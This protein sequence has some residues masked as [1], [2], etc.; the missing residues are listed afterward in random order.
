MMIYSRLQGVEVVQME[1]VNALEG[2][3]M[4]LEDV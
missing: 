3:N 1:G 2:M 4:S